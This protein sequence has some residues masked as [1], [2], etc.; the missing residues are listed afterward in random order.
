MW[1]LKVHLLSLTHLESHT[2]LPPEYLKWKLVES[3]GAAAD[4]LGDRAVF[5]AFTPEP[6]LLYTSAGDD[7]RG[8]EVILRFQYS[9]TIPPE[10]PAGNYVGQMVLTMAESP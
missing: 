7:N 10:A 5:Q 2:P 8:R 1:Y 9:L 3:T 4:L 6:V